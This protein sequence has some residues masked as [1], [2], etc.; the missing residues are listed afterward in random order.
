VGEIASPN[1]AVTGKLWPSPSTG[2]HLT[3]RI[4]DREFESTFRFVH[5]S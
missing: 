3:K 2:L 1:D 4:A 5:R